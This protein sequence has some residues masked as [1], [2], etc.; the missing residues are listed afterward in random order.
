MERRKR[1]WMQPLFQ[2]RP[3]EGEYYRLLPEL[4]KQP[5]RFYDCLRMQPATFDYLLEHVRPQLVQPHSRFRPSF[6]PEE[7]LFYTLRFL[8]TGSSFRS[9]EFT[10]RVSHQSISNIVLET[11]RALWQQL[12][13]K[14]LKPPATPDDYRKIEDGFFAIWNLPNCLGAIDGKHIRLCC[15]AHTGSIFHNYKSFFSIVLQGVCD[16]YHRFTH[17]SIG[18][19]GST[20][21]GGIFRESALGKSLLGDHASFQHLP[22]TKLPNSDRICSHFFIGDNAYAL[23]TW[24]MVP[25]S[26]RSRKPRTPEE[27]QKRKTYNYRH[28]RARRSIESAFG[29]LSSKF[30][31]LR[32]CLELEPDKADNIVVACCLLHNIIINLEGT[33]YSASEIFDFANEFQ[34]QEREHS[35]IDHQQLRYNSS[36]EAKKYRE[37]LKEFFSNE[38]KIYFEEIV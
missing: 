26:N 4:R 38:G 1:W 14:H 13:E 30:R 24:M 36:I 28:S 8:S 9:M 33:K 18:G 25:F 31:C 20:S 35:P 3:T 11:T 34:Q 7:K 16:A 17:I 2:S 5:D 22:P 15:P 23:K 37:E 32:T 19:Q 6:A 27:N 10:T 29:I 12:A 21:D